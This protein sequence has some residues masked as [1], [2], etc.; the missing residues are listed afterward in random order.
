MPGIFRSADSAA[1]REICPA[2][3]SFR[4]CV[5]GSGIGAEA[6]SQHVA[7]ARTT[8]SPGPF[9]RRGSVRAAGCFLPFGTASTRPERKGALHGS[10]R[11]DCDGW[12]AW[13]LQENNAMWLRGN[14]WVSRIN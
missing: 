3:R 13:V 8:L 9:S 4:G 14:A 2:Q 7:P 6:R 11:I 1:L 10:E 12:K 5:Q